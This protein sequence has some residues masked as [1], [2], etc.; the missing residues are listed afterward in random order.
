MSEAEQTE[1]GGSAGGVRRSSARIIAITA[2][3]VGSWPWVTWRPAQTDCTEK[4]SAPA[5]DA[6]SGGV[7]TRSSVVQIET[8][9]GPAGVSSPE[10]SD[11]TRSL[12][13]T[14][15]R[16]AAGHE[17]GAMS[18]ASEA[19]SVPCCGE[20]SVTIRRAT[21]PPSYARSQRRA[22]TPPAE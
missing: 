6:V 7:D 21:D 13:V 17:S 4:S 15:W 9:R 1:D 14:S 19:R 18:E 2:G 10:F 22:V 16:Q 8:H 11:R 5:R 12:S 3:S 20:P